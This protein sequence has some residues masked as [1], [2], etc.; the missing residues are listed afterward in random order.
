MYLGMFCLRGE[1]G[2]LN[3]DDICTCVVN[4]QFELEFLIQFMFTFTAGSVCSY[5]IVV[6]LSVRL[7][8]YHMWWVQWLQ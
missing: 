2:F 3:C 7:S 1:P 4:K 6:G 8:W 5:A